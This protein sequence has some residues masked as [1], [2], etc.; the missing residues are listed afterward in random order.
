MFSEQLRSEINLHSCHR[1]LDNV[2]LFENI[3]PSIVGT[4]LG[5]LHAEVFMP[6]DVILRA[7]DT[8]DSV[9]FINSG[10]VAIYSLKGAEVNTD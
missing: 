5:C 9:Y 7:G 10:T 1:L 4:I 2:S 3:P 8:V 6:N